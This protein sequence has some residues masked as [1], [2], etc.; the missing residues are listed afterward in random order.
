MMAPDCQH[1]LQVLAF[2]QGKLLCLR[3]SQSDEHAVMVLNFGEEPATAE[4]PFPM[5]RWRKSLDSADQRW[6]ARWSLCP[7]LLETDG[8]PPHNWANFG[9][10]LSV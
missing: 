9:S 1:D 7:G 8:T 2:E 10:P 3:M 5:A 6:N 4:L